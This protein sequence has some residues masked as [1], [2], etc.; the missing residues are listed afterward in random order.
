M[1][2]NDETARLCV[3][4]TQ[5]LLPLKSVPASTLALHDITIHVESGYYTVLLPLVEPQSDM[6]LLYWGADTIE[7]VTTFIRLL[8]GGKLKT[9]KVE[10]YTEELRRD[11]EKPLSEDELHVC[12]TDRIKAFLQ[13]CKDCIIVEW[14]FDGRID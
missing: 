5:N 3:K 10:A 4:R 6:R 8:Q 13:P 9:L 7:E 11:I 2:R 1:D 12:S 14:V